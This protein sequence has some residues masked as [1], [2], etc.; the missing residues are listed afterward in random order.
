MT[1]DGAT[2]SLRG[3][4]LNEWKSRRK[5]RGQFQRF[6]Y[7]MKVKGGICYECLLHLFFRPSLLTFVE[8]ICSTLT[9]QIS[10]TRPLKCSINLWDHP[11][12]SALD[13][14]HS[15]ERKD[16]NSEGDKKGH[17]ISTYPEN[18]RSSVKWCLAEHEQ[19]PNKGPAL[20]TTIC[21]RGCVNL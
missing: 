21:R 13:S 9:F 18:I 17:P 19:K 2:I 14:F 6:E 12:S 15:K 11:Q 16:F 3:L 8:F 10:V 20:K 5:W 1:P 7:V 4:Y